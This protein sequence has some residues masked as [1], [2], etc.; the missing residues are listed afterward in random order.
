MK[1]ILDYYL[2]KCYQVHGKKIPAEYL[3]Y[4]LVAMQ[5]GSVRSFAVGFFTGMVAGAALMWLIALII[6]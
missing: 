3:S 5:S 2:E 1:K 6:L 4:L